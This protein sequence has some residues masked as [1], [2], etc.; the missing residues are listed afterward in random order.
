VV[1]LTQGLTL[2]L[3]AGDHPS[4]VHA[5]LDDLQG[6]AAWEW[7]FLPRSVNDPKTAFAENFLEEVGPDPGA[8]RIGGINGLM[9]R[10]R[11]VLEESSGGVMGPQQIVHSNAQ[12]RA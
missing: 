1:R 5:K 11:R 10:V 2:G 3:E 12:G 9:S 4:G 8:Q 7:L 6:D